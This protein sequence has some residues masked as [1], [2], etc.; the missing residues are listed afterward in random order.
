M[1]H[2]IFCGENDKDTL[3]N[4]HTI[5]VSLIPTWEKKIK[6]CDKC[7]KKIHRYIIKDLVRLVLGIKSSYNDLGILLSSRGFYEKVEEAAAP[8]EEVS[9]V[10]RSLIS[11]IPNKGRGERIYIDEIA[12]GCNL[13][14]Q[15]VGYILGD[16]GIKKGRANP[17][18]YL[19]LTKANVSKI[20]KLSAELFPELN[21]LN[22][23]LEECLEDS[24]AQ[25]TLFPEDV[26]THPS[27]GKK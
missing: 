8:I 21:L 4:H 26:I 3:I 9:M 11:F 16:M 22:L 17:G 27:G 7:H 20:V 5:P 24:H 10:L 23:K 14:N 1:S 12:K 19:Y 18:M 13:T 25:K 15:K 6:V 2:C